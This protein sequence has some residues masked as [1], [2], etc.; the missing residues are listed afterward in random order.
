MPA[1]NNAKRI[2][3]LEELIRMHQD[4]YYNAQPIISDEDFDALWDELGRLD[5]ANPLLR[6]LGED[7]LDGWP[8]SRHVMP[9]GSQSKA[10]DPAG[11]YAWAAKMPFSRFIVQYKLDGASL[12]LQYEKGLLARAVTRGDGAWGDEITPNARRMNGVLGN[13]PVPFDGA[14]RGEV[15]M[16]HEVHAAKY[17]DK[18]NCRNAANGLMKRKDGTGSEDL[19]VICYDAEGSVGGGSAFGDEREKIEWLSSAGFTVVPTR[20]L[21]SPKEVVEYRGMVMTERASLDHDIDGLVIKGIEIDP[22]DLAKPRPEKQIAFKFS[23]E[24]AV[25]RLVGVE[26]SESGALYTPI[27]IVEPVRLAGTTVQRANLCNPDMIRGMD[28]MIGSMVVITKRGEIIPKIE[29][30][31]ENPESAR[32]IWQP[33]KCETCGSALVDGGTSLYCPNEKCP[34]KEL[35]RLDKWLSVLDIKDFGSAILQR[36]HDSGRVRTIADLYTLEAG[37]LSEFERMGAVLARK[38]LRNLR[39]VREVSLAEFLAGFD[40]EGVGLL[41]AE[42][43]IAAGFDT[44]EALFAASAEDLDRAEG[45]AEKMAETIRAGLASLRGEMEAV[46]ES[47]AVAIRKPSAEA[48]A[49]GEGASAVRGKSFCI[50]GELRSMKRPEAEKLIRDLGGSA[51]SSVSKDLDYLVTN[52]Q[53][54][55]SSKNLKAKQLGIPVIDEDAFLRMAGK[56]E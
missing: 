48:P 44:L 22:E 46:I 25:T 8:K 51:R 54:S 14:V 18:A 17:P 52:D 3:E 34:K 49:G 40:I 15:L 21:D 23:P 45:I 26:W 37:E 6:K 16:S 29:T 56:M 10:T 12:E 24:E 55:G 4:L 50:T 36:L 30:L 33:E 47:G 31:V 11:F 28:L 53:S 19:D 42:K 41:V 38:I 35:H 43:L 7:R 1:S 27:G 32:P 13:L 20:I 2:R 5:P 39:A 9:M